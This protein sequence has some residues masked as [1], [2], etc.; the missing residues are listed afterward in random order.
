MEMYHR[1]DR[2]TSA[3]SAEHVCKHTLGVRGL[4]ICPEVFSSHI[5][6]QNGTF[7][8]NHRRL[9]PREATEV[10][11]CWVNKVSHKLSK[12]SVS[13]VEVGAAAD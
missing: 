6:L 1:G 12:V 9:T 3:M 4:L 11:R 13:L 7:P 8:G 5:H 10:W 2:R